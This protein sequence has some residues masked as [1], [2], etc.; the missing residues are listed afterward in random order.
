MGQLFSL[1]L[2]PVNVAVSM[3]AKWLSQLFMPSE[4]RNLGH[5]YLLKPS[6]I[7]F[8]SKIHPRRTRLGVAKS[9]VEAIR[10][11]THIHPQTKCTYS[12]ILTLI[13]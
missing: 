12:I 11:P 2:M 5:P 1:P 8:F 4:S 13:E 7:L 9:T 6:S 3:T 10:Y